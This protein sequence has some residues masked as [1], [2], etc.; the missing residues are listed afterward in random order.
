MQVLNQQALTTL[1]L[2]RLS[3]LIVQ[4]TRECAAEDRALLGRA[5]LSTYRDLCALGRRGEAERILLSR[6]TLPRRTA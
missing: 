5:I 6:R 1:F 3:R 2:G 4:E